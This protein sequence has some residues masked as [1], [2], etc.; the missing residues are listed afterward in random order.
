[1]SAETVDQPIVLKPCPFCG[2]P[3]VPVVIN[4]HL[5]NGAAIA[6]L[7]DY[8]DEGVLVDAF[9]FCHECGAESERHEACL[10]ER[11]DYRQA[12]A[13]G[14]ASWQGRDSRHEKLY[15]FSA[16]KGLNLFPRGKA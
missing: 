10:Y 14:V 9:V 3:P 8:G 5:P 4:G 1:M 13:E 6:E 2:G 16:S 15:L 11:D 7:D 12:L